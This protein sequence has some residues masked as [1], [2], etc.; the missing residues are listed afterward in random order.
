MQS[1]LEYLQQHQASAGMVNFQLPNSNGHNPGELPKYASQGQLFPYFAKSGAMP[2][3]SDPVEQM[4]DPLPSPK[5]S[6]H[7]VLD[8]SLYGYPSACFSKPEYDPLMSNGRFQQMFAAPMPSPDYGQHRGLAPAPHGPPFNYQ[9]IRRYTPHMPNGQAQQSSAAPKPS[10]GRGQQHQGLAPAPHEQVQQMHTAK[11]PLL[12]GQQHQGLARAPHGHPASNHS[13]LTH[14]PQMSNGQVP[15]QLGFSAMMPP[16]ARK[17]QQSGPTHVAAAMP[18]I[19][20]FVDPQTLTSSPYAPENQIPQQNLY[21]IY[22]AMQLRG[23]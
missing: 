20:A 22:Q 3:M 9:S 11:N 21:Q 16:Q 18:S 4:Y 13:M 6:Q 15:L 1:P 8:P 12:Y 5:Y 19:P 2:K 17:L 7:H 23:T 10:P 14:V